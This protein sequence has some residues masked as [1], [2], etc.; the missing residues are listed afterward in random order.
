MSYY[1]QGVDLGCIRRNKGNLGRATSFGLQKNKHKK[2]RRGN[3][4]EFQVSINLYKYELDIPSKGRDN[5]SHYP[6]GALD[7]KDMATTGRAAEDVRHVES[8]A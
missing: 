5:A 1:E 7:I 6:W 2:E 3:S 4:D 8:V